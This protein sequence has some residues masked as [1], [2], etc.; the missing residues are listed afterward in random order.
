MVTFCY[1]Y[2]IEGQGHPVFR[3]ESNLPECRVPGYSNRPDIKKEPES[4]EEVRVTDNL[5]SRDTTILSPER[6]EN[7][8]SISVD[9]EKCTPG[10]RQ[11]LFLQTKGSPVGFREIGGG[12][13]DRHPQKDFRSEYTNLSG[14]V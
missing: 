8:E 7:R 13:T 6:K 2:V 11:V 3:S 4:Q 1:V 9:V 14:W 5:E 12:D 10:V